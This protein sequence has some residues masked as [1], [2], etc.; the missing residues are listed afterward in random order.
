VSNAVKQSAPEQLTE[1]V[2]I[3]VSPSLSTA[4]KAAAAAAGMKPA[5]AARAAFESFVEAVADEDDQAAS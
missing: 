5:E 1:L 4:F 2:A 3:R